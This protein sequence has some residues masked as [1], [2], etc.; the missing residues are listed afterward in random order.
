[1]PA[2]GSF[3]R[4]K[5]ENPDPTESNA[6]DISNLQDRDRSKERHEEEKGEHVTLGDHRTID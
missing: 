6:L 2:A 3:M 1:M 4:A 5:R